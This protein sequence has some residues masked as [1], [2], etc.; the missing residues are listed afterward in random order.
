MS[1]RCLI[2]SQ[3]LLRKHV[4]VSGVLD[5][6]NLIYSGLA[7]SHGEGGFQAACLKWCSG[8]SSC[9]Q[10]GE[11]LGMNQQTKTGGDDCQ[12]LQL[13]L[14]ILGRLAGFQGVRCIESLSRTWYISSAVLGKSQR[15]RNTA[16]RM[17]SVFPSPSG[18]V[19][20]TVS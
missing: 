15:C 20:S 1:A 5:V 13:L 11:M 9:C 19:L 8:K 7:V 12:R 16:G 18:R 4:R 14:G 6:R 2:A 10:T 17:W 3:L